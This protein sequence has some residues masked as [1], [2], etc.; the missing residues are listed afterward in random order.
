MVNKSVSQKGCEG[1]RIKNVTKKAVLLGVMLTL[2]GG[3]VFGIGYS[4]M[5]SEGSGFQDI[6]GHPW[7]YLIQIY[8]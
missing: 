8:D 4:M 3:A 5:K 6:Q 1:M 7:Y 2:L